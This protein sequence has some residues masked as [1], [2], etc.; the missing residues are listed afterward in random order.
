MDFVRTFAANKSVC[1]KRIIGLMV[2]AV[3]SHADNWGEFEKRWGPDM[4][5]LLNSRRCNSLDSKPIRKWAWWEEDLCRH[6]KSRLSGFR[7]SIECKKACRQF[8]RDSFLCEIPVYRVHTVD[9][10]TQS[11]VPVPYP[12]LVCRFA[13]GL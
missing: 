6:F 7:T 11:H 4:A 8:A 12:L 3:A 5:R 2:G 10:R 1:H 13:I 9:V